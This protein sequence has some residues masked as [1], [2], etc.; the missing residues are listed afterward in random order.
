MY[1]SRHLLI[2]FITVVFS[3][4][5]AGMALD[6]EQKCTDKDRSQL[7]DFAGAMIGVNIFWFLWWAAVVYANRGGTGEELF[8]LHG[9]TAGYKAGFSILTGLAVI[10]GIITSSLALECAA[11]C[12]NEALQGV[13][14]FTLCWTVIAGGYTCYKLYGGYHPQ[15]AIELPDEQKKSINDR[16]K[17]L[18]GGL[19]S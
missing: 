17:N 16:L 15:H 3:I 4:V 6:C 14:G 7:R 9:S 13:A 2:I 12:Q 8:P 19:K 18:F 11:A 5:S 10:F 1:F